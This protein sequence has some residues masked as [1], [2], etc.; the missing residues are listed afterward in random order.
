M[1]FVIFEIFSSNYRR[2]SEIP[3]SA[4]DGR[5]MSDSHRRYAR[6]D[7]SSALDGRAY[8]RIGA[9]SAMIGFVESD[10]LQEGIADKELTVLVLWSVAR[11][12]ACPE[13]GIFVGLGD[14]GAVRWVV[15]GETRRKFAR[16]ILSNF[17]LRRGENVVEWVVV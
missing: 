8:L 12:P 4:S 1:A 7:W 3:W 9:E 5:S 15:K 16:K 6:C 17:L 13:T 2:T 11:F 10:G 14:V